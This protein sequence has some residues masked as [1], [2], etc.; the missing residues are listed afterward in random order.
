MVFA[1]LA[2]LAAGQPSAVVL[3]PVANMYS[4]ASAQT[5]VVS[6]AIYGATVRLLEERAGWVRIE[7]PDRYTGWMP[8]EWLRPLGEG[9]RAYASD[10]PVAQVESLFSNLYR[11][12]D[13]TRRRPLLTLPFEA[14]LEVRAEP[15][16]ND[17]RWVEVRLADGG[18]AWVQRGD[19]SFDVAPLPVPSLIEFSRRFLGLPYLWGGTSTFGYDCSGFTQMLCRRRGI[20]IPRDAG[21]QARWE[22]M[23]PVER[24]DLQPGDLLYFGSSLEKISHTGM[25]FGD[26]EFINATTYQRPTVRVDRLDDPHWVKLYVCARRLR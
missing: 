9:E 10:G 25:Y 22:G 6:Q 20:V 14:R 17:R 12:P 7:T 3:K 15:E 4:G 13:V 26:G 2:M 23:V 1:V 21:P 5:D 19:L 18:A 11:E 24:A 8:E 16:D